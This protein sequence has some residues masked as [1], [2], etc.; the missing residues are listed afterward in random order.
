MAPGTFCRMRFRQ[1]LSS[2]SMSGSPRPGSFLES[3][4]YTSTSTSGS[5]SASCEAQGRGESRHRPPTHRVPRPGGILSS[6]APHTRGVDSNLPPGSSGF[7]TPGFIKK[8]ASHLGR[9]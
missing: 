1:T 9:P 2:Q 3:R 7:T 8:L 4:R 5:A 6:L